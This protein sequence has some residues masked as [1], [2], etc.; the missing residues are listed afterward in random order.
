MARPRQPLYRLFSH[1]I[2]WPHH[3]KSRAAAPEVF[4]MFHLQVKLFTK[5]ADINNLKIK[6]IS[7]SKVPTKGEHVQ[8][9][10]ILVWS[11]QKSIRD[12]FYPPHASSVHNIAHAE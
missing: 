7:Y 12:S 6:F 10:I 2:M 8:I 3:F 11:I 5:T 1:Y 9:F 4:Q